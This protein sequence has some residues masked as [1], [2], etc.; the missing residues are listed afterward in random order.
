MQLP[1][2]GKQRG[3]QASA[4][5]SIHV[6]TEVVDEKMFARR[7]TGATARVLKNR[8]IGLRQ[9]RFVTGDK[10]IEGL[11]YLWIVFAD[12]LPVKCVRVRQQH[13]ACYVG[14]RDERERCRVDGEHV[15]I[16]PRER[17]KVEREAEFANSTCMKRG[18]CDEAPTQPG[19]FYQRVKIRRGVGD[20]TRFRDAPFWRAVVKGQKNVTEITHEH[21]NHARDIATLRL[22]RG[23]TLLY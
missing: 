9:V 4:A 11:K 23:A 10:V 6:N 2:T 12:P 15:A 1:R 18:W 20:A 5:S 17:R 22:L 7:I 19:R 21:V 8:C 14:V 3:L 16:H 13:A